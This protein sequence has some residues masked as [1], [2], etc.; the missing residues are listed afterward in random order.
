MRSIVVAIFTAGCGRI[1][2]DEPPMSIGCTSP[3]IVDTFDVGPACSAWGFVDVVGATVSVGGGELVIAPAPNSD[4]VTRGGC[5][6]TVAI[7]FD[8][9]S[10]IFAQSATLPGDGEYKELIAGGS[11]QSWLLNWQRP[12]SF[13]R[14][15]PDAPPIVLATIPFDPRLMS[16]LRMRPSADLSA[17]VAEYSDDGNVWYQFGFDP[18]PAADQVQ[19]LIYGGTYA[20]EPTPSVITFDALDV[21]P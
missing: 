7:P 15:S 19:V 6:S 16:W 4:T 2:F 20:N 1:A 12:L 5:Y 8:P 10:G 9:A 3:A 11:S 21:C 13:S 14:N 18:T 17:V